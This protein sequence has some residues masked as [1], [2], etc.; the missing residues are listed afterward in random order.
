MMNNT[1]KNREWLLRSLDEL[2]L[3]KTQR[4]EFYKTRKEMLKKCLAELPKDE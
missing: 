1:Y 4:D 2:E 3:E